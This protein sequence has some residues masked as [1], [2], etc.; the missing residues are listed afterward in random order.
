MRAPVRLPKTLDIHPARPR[1][2]ALLVADAAPTWPG[3]TRRVARVAPAPAL[4]DVLHLARANGKLVRGLEGA[5]K[6]LDAEKKG[7]SKELG[8]VA[9][10][11]RLSRLLLVSEDGSERFGREVEKLLESHADRL[12]AI[13]IKATGPAFHHGIFGDEALVQ[14]LLLTDKDAVCRALLALAGV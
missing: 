6:T 10:E 2:E 13:R 3:G 11:P 1:V 7:L 12:A 9:K 4:R 5:E 8:N 14:A